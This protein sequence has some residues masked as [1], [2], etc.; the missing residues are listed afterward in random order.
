MPDYL[1]VRD[2]VSIKNLEVRVHPEVR[3]TLAFLDIDEQGIS[4]PFQ[5][6]TDFVSILL[7]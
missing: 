6:G 4:L 3:D 7:L 5:S 2:F 1:E